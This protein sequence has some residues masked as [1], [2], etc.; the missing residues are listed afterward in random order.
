L[1]G[2]VDARPPLDHVEVDLENTLLRE[3]PLGERRQGEV[4]RFAGRPTVRREKQVLH[5]L[6][7]D[8]R[9]AAE[10]SSTGGFVPNFIELLPVDAVVLI[11]TT[12]LGGDHGAL[13]VERNLP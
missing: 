12:V 11:E 13:Q 7:R 1:V 8:G 5:Q 3:D 4:E 10:T 6:L 9:A 2:S